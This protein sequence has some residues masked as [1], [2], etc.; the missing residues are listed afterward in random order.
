MNQF[1][2]QLSPQAGGI[3]WWGRLKESLERPTNPCLNSHPMFTIKMQ[4]SALQRLFLPMPLQCFIVLVLVQG[5][6][7]VVS[8]FEELI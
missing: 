2:D 4:T 1:S 5:P 7:Y 8:A 6:E 3:I